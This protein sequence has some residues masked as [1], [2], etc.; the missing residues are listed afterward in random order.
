[1]FKQYF[2]IFLTN[3][4]EKFPSPS[5]RGSP[6]RIHLGKS[7]EGQKYDFA[8]FDPKSRIFRQKCVR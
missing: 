2:G 5:Y 3:F 1:M 7:K 6:I 8:I 4:D